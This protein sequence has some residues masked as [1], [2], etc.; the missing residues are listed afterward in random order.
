MESE[1]NE[2]QSPCVL[3]ALPS[4]NETQPPCALTA[5]PSVNEEE[6]FMRLFAE[7]RNILL[8]GPAGTGKTYTV[9]NIIKLISHEEDVSTAVIAAP[10]G[11]AAVQIGGITIHSLFDIS[12]YDVKPQ[13]W[14]IIPK[15]DYFECENTPNENPLINQYHEFIKG[16][17]RKS[18]F[19]NGDIKYLFVDEISMAGATLLIVVDTI[20]R[21]RGRY[22]S[23]LP[24]GGVQCIFSGDFYQL[25]PVK[26]CY[27]CFTK[28]WQ[29]MEIAII[30]FVKCKR[31]TGEGSLDHFDMVCRL[32]KGALN[33][34]DKQ[35]LLSRKLAY[36]N[37]EHKLLDI[38]PIVLYSKNINI[39]ELN[40]KRL[41]EIDSPSVLFT[42]IDSKTIKVKNADKRTREKYN[43]AMD[44]QLNNML[45]NELELKV[46]AQVIFNRNYSNAEKLVNGKMA[47]VISIK[48]NDEP[49]NSI[50]NYV[51]RIR[52][53]E[54]VEHDISPK[55]FEISTAKYT[56]SRVQ[57]PFRLA[58][59]ISIHR[60]QGITLEYV[61]LDI[62]DVFCNGQAYVALS[63]CV[64]LA[65][66]YIKNLRFDR[67]NADKKILKMFQ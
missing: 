24:M 65:N 66:M 67:I 47:K 40:N 53:S 64:S 44:V 21:T 9:K 16:I 8:H 54:G 6:S 7:K 17:I 33:S 56:C 13:F 19:N 18:Q 11:M 4:V 28:I 57:F 30:D 39:D 59:V 41:A 58:W 49:G 3:T 37:N 38:E 34:E 63:R 42:S 22:N 31:F 52:T 12:P 43:N 60:S 23:R 20:L 35:M 29:N 36:V 48:K 14:E 50:Y 1:K 62:S 46:G 27:C 55:L 61:V 10:T 15:Y 5:L 2:T 51:V 45:V 32:R 26:D 25:P